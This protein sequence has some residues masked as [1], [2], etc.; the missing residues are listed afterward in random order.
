[1]Y[2]EAQKK[3]AREKR[4]RQTTRVNPLV[5]PLDES[6]SVDWKA[7]L[8]S[9]KKREPATTAPAA[10]PTTAT[11]SRSLEMWDQDRSRPGDR[12]P[13]IIHEGTDHS[14]QTPRIDTDQ[15]H[16]RPVAGR[17]KSQVEV[18]LRGL[19]DCRVIAR[20]QGHH[21]GFRFDVEM[22]DGSCLSI[23]GPRNQIRADAV[24]YAAELLVD[25][26]AGFRRKSNRV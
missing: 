20:D 12:G 17:E 11:H 19:P 1:M 4:Q 5:M 14:R 7:F 2:N 13:E 23:R 16:W 15:I 9:R 26:H 10:R 22:P 21:R 6:G 3:L 8:A 25:C 18:W 24:Q